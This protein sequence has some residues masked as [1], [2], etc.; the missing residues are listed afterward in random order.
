MDMVDLNPSIRN[1]HKLTMEICSSIS[2]LKEFL[3]ESTE[4]VHIPPRS[5]VFHKPGVIETVGEVN[6]VFIGDLHGDYYTLLQVL[7]AVW[8]RFRN[9]YFLVFLG[10][11]IDRGYMQL[12]T[13]VF[14]LLLKGE[15]GSQVVLLRGNHEPPSWLIPE[16][17]DFIYELRLKFGARG[18]EIYRY[19]SNLFDKLPL[20]LLH[21]GLL[22]SLHGGPPLR[23]L[24]SSDWR[25]AFGIGRDSF[26]P[27]VVEEI[28]WSDPV[29]IPVGYA[30]SPRGAGVVYG[31]S[32]TRKLL[33]ISNTRVLIRGHEAVDG[34]KESHNGMVITVFTSPLVYG[35]RCGG[36]LIYEY[37]RREDN[38]RSSKIC[39]YPRY[40]E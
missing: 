33:E 17:H 11:Y 12:E 16:P 10:D 30:P 32:I 4:V 19:S 31:V 1:L 27:R 2:T 7:D 34:F 28:L 23:V 22:I 15:Y 5:A 8:S 36:V 26:E 38:Y 35:F 37:S 14:L 6:Y 29:E 20:S 24:S 9:G 3:V 21:R 25:E 18:D 40:L 39:I 13:L